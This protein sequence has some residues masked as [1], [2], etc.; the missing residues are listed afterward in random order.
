MS[1]FQNVF[2]IAFYNE[3]Y[4]VV[5]KSGDFDDETSLKSLNSPKA[6][7]PPVPISEIG[8]GDANVLTINIPSGQPEIEP[9][10]E[11]EPVESDDELTDVSSV[12]SPRVNTEVVPE[13]EVTKEEPVM[14]QPVSDVK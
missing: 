10:T 4:L 11:N 2:P 8:A 3:T 7:E 13:E 6:E 5:E 14:T 12:G 9:V 1:N